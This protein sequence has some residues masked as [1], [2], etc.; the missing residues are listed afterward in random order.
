MVVKLAFAVPLARSSSVVPG[1]RA[2][3]EGIFP[4]RAHTFKA[5]FDSSLDWSFENEAIFPDVDN[6]L[7][8]PLEVCRGSTIRRCYGLGDDGRKGDNKVVFMPRFGLLRHL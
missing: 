1:Q 7:Q 6:S 4:T 5:S 2:I 8:F 3:L